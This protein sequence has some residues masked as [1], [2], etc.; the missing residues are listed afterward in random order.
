MENQP[1]TV[2][3]VWHPNFLRG[4][5]FANEIYCRLCADPDKPLERAIGIPVRFRSTP[6]ESNKKSPDGIQFSSGRAAI[7]A[8]IDDEMVVDREWKTYLIGLCQQCEKRNRLHRFYP[9]ALSPH[10]FKISAKI[11]ETN[12]IRLQD[13]PEVAQ[14]G[15]LLTQLAHELSRL[16]LDQ[17][18]AGERLAAH[19]AG[20]APVTIFLSHAKQDGLQLAKGFREYI[21]SNTQLNFFFDARD[22]PPGTQWQQVL[23]QASGNRANALLIFN[24]DQYS[25]R[26]WCRIEVLQAKQ[27]WL[28]ALVINA[29]EQVERRTFPYTGNLLSVRWPLEGIADPYGTILGLLLYEV[30]HAAYFPVRVS[31]LAKLLSLGSTFYP[32]PYPPELLTLLAMKRIITS[33]PKTTFVY[34]N[35]PLGTE[36]RAIL[37]EAA[38]GIRMVTPS[39]FPA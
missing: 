14:V 20:A 30:L 39:L 34:P 10:S 13:I 18:R 2:Y 36:E 22:I 17:P 4:E 29:C 1:L 5:W 31:F 27:G 33:S 26:E 9:V 8:L 35:P 28:P 12:F 15:V 25:S 3:V 32:I 23:K 19:P 21:V 38:P 16:I 37:K 11:A 24:T 6:S 7:V